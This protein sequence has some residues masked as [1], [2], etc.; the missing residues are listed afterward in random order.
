[1]P[2]SSN[3]QSDAKKLKRCARRK[4]FLLSAQ[5]STWSLLHICRAWSDARKIDLFARNTEGGFG[6]KRIMVIQKRN[7]AWHDKMHGI[8]DC[9]KYPEILNENLAALA[10]KLQLGHG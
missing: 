8:V 6:L 7:N 9:M 4:S 1:M 3:L 2:K 10:K 5:V